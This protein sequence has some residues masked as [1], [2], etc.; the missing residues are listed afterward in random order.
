MLWVGLTSATCIASLLAAGPILKS[1]N[2]HESD[3]VG[4]PAQGAVNYYCPLDFV[5]ELSGRYCYQVGYVDAHGNCIATGCVW[6][7]VPHEID[8]P[9]CSDPIITAARPVEFP[10][11]IQKPSLAPKPDPLFTGV[12]R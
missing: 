8:C 9:N 12:L 10:K 6:S 7:S 3:H 11:D 4:R 2:A 5:G 1:S